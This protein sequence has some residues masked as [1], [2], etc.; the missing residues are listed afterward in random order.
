MVSSQRLSLGQWVIDD[1]KMHAQIV[2]FDGFDPLDVIAPYEVLAAGSDYVGGEMEV[3]LV[4]AEGSRAVISRGR[5]RRVGQAAALRRLRPVG[6]VQGAALRL[7]QG[8]RPGAD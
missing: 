2:L 5:G 8:D 3:D 7:R 4:S 6:L 1:D